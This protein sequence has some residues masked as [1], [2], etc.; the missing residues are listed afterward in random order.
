M[1]P[2]IF[3]TEMVRAILDNR[4]TVTRRLIKDTNI[5]NWWDYEVDGTPIAFIEQETGDFYP[6]TYPCRYQPGDILYVRET[7]AKQCGLYW[8]KAGLIFD[9]NGRNIH[10]IVVPQK[11]YS[12]AC[13]PREA[14]RIFLRVA[15]VRVEKLQ[16]ITE[17]GAL[18]EG[19]EKIQVNV[20]NAKNVFEYKIPGTKQV[21]VSAC[22]AYLNLWNRKIKPADRALYGWEANP[23]VWIIEFE[24]ISKEEAQQHV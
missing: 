5:L 1:K 2:I 22:G 3:N 12:P 17:I 8:H 19:I 6:P 11:W 18:Q 21:C 9:E 14:A 16:D 24:K 4:K 7:W 23:W 10:G 15:D 13:M 20:F